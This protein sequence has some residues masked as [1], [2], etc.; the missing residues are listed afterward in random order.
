MARDKIFTAWDETHSLLWGQQPIK[1]E[2]RLDKSPLFS[3]ER[4]AELK[5]QLDRR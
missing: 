4:L 3:T 2:H 1:L 5:T